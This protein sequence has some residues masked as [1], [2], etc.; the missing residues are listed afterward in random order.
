[1]RTAYNVVLPWNPSD[2]SEG[3]YAS[4]VW[5]TSAD[6]ALRLVATEMA[7]S[8]EKVFE[9]DAEREEYIAI[10]LDCS[11]GYV[12]EALA[13]LK[14]SLAFVFKE[15]LFPDGVVKPIDSMALCQIMVENRERL[16][17]P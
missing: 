3:D 13:D 17:K 5:A 1:M 7:S 8:G 10:L 16:I 12:A 6:E 4:A 2:S 15:Q 9:T 11:G 14:S